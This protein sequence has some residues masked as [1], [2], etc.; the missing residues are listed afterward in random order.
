LNKK[1][2]DGV[3]SRENG[4]KTNDKA[5]Q[6]KALPFEHYDNLLINSHFRRGYN[7]QMESLI[8]ALQIVNLN[9]RRKLA[10]KT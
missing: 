1:A 4:C 3:R 2:S 10:I 5:A 8:I 6:R 7:T 9:V